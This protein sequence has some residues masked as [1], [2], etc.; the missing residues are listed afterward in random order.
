MTLKDGQ[1]L[2]RTMRLEVTRQDGDGPA[3]F[4]AAL[5]SES[6]VRQF[7]GTEVLD[8]SKGAVD[9]ERAHDGG[10][11]LLFN[12]NRD[13]ALGRVRNIVLDTKEKKL[14]GDLEFSPH[15][16]TAQRMAAEVADGFLGDVSVGYAIH[17]HVVEMERDEEIYR[18]TSWTPNEV[19][20]VTVPADAS[21]GVGRQLTEGNSMDPKDKGK[22]PEG[23]NTPGTVVD[24]SSARMAGLNEGARQ[25]T[26]AERARVAEIN[27]L[28]ASLTRSG[29][30]FSAL[31]DNAIADG[32]TLEATQRS[33]LSLIDTTPAE[34]VSGDRQETKDTPDPTVEAGTDAVDKFL[35]GA[36][37]ALAFRQSLETSREASRE[38][39]TNE[40]TG[41]SALELARESL[42]VAGVSI[43]GLS[44]DALIAAAFRPDG[45]GQRDLVG[46]S[47][48]VFTN[49]LEG[50]ANKALLMGYDETPETWS[51]WCRITNLPDF[52]TNSR[53]GLS[54]FSD[55]D[56]VPENGEYK[57][58][59]LDDRKESIQAKKYGKLF[60]ITREA[61]INDD[62]DGMSRVPRLMGRAAARKVGDLVYDILNNPPT[63]NQD[64]TALF[65]SSNTGTAGAP[66]VT[67]VSELRVKMALQT[68]QNSQASGLNIRP[69]Y[70]IVPVTLEDTA[71]V[72][73]ASE[74]DP[75]GLTGATGGAVQPNP[76]RNIAQV[77]ADPRL[78]AASTTAWY[79]AA[80]Q[81]ATDTV[82]V[83]FINGQQEPQLFSRDGWSTD[84]VEYK[85]RH[86][87]G[88]APLDFRGMAKNAGA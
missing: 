14:R 4:R 37:K 20:L 74:T 19:S 32:W 29:P 21:V 62:L 73:L 7:F 23:D 11:A 10:L 57:H 9:L 17:S 63:L 2:T 88:V 5:S 45:Y 87:V 36:S 51:I 18:I 26:E 6:P 12:H 59:T 1:T 43:A 68:D 82:E 65:R 47:T 55:L 28:F 54:Q 42:R 40:F 60:G 22:S 69:A 48:S 85:V 86:E 35:D 61:I 30:E 83:G 70:M 80:D 16:E 53:V 44:R 24:F 78:D 27:T 8:H 64:A 15:S 39:R 3:T 66:S 25:G 58:G 46:H 52:K 49:L 71:R 13:Q 76:I 84:G 79:M 50:L 31:R 77:V 75:K 33:L 56:E 41:F 81:N 34:P 38:M 72:L 67:T